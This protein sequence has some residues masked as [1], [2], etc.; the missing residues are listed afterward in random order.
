[1]LNLEVG[2]IYLSNEG[3]KCFIYAHRNG[4]FLGAF[5]GESK[6]L[7]FDEHGQTQCLNDCLVKE[8][9]E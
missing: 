3:R 5:I 2:K 1:M 4:K 7:S 8:L 9:E 6:P